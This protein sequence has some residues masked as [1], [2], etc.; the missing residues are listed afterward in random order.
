MLCHLLSGW[1]LQLTASTNQATAAVAATASAASAFVDPAFTIAVSV[2]PTVCVPASATASARLLL[3]PH[4]CFCPCCGSFCHFHTAGKC[5]SFPSVTGM[6]A[7]RCETAFAVSLSWLLANA[8]AFASLSM[9]LLPCVHGASTHGTINSHRAELLSLMW[10][11]SR[12]YEQPL[13]CLAVLWRPQLWH[14]SWHTR[15][16]CLVS[17]MCPLVSVLCRS[18]VLHELLWSHVVQ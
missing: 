11:D 8:T 5:N 18:F 15:Y 3:L 10:R 9:P 4:C 13:A 7:G 6:P 17:S 2:T 16:F 14:E 12:K 1:C